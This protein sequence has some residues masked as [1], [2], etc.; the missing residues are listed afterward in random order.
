MSRPPEHQFVGMADGARLA[1]SV[2]GKPGSGVP[3]L[4]NRPLGGSMALWGKFAERLAEHLQVIA[5]D[6]RG[7]GASSDVPP[8]HSTRAMAR[9][10]A[11]VMDEL[12]FA[13][14]HVFGLSLGGMVASWLAI[15]APERVVRLVLASTV[16]EVGAVSHRI[17]RHAL[18]LLRSLAIPGAHAEVGLVRE[19]LSPQFRE[20]HPDRVRE[21]ELLVRTT[22][23]KRRNL[24]LLALAA[25][26]HS[27]E[28]EMEGLRVQ[29]LLLFGELDLIARRASQAEL[30]HDLPNAKLEVMPGAGH[31]ITLEQPE[32]AADRVISFLHDGPSEV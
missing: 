9:D 1:F 19:I 13:R 18:P 23:A 15:D 11:R 31:D 29:T 24:M 3:L 20:A 17:T 25:A 22:P 21:I 6:P 8:F 28:P 26:W 30:L 14:A 32:Q 2:T 16:P 5:F 7:V 12:G 10:A 27:A 4:L